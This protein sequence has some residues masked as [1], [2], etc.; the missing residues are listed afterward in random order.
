MKYLNS[1][2]FYNIDTYR[3]DEVNCYERAIGLCLASYKKEYANLFFM[4]S[5]FK[6]CYYPMLKDSELMNEDLYLVR[7]YLNLDCSTVVIKE[8]N[9]FS[10][11]EERLSKNCRVIVLGNLRQ[12]SYSEFYKEANWGHPF[13]IKGFD[14]QKRIFYILDY[15]HLRSNVVRES[16][17]TI[18]YD[19]LKSIFC[20]YFKEIEN[21]TSSFII[22]FSGE[23]TILHQTKQIFIEIMEYVFNQSFITHNEIELLKNFKK[24]NDEDL[25]NYL[26]N[27]PKKK[28][29]F[30]HIMLDYLHANSL[31]DSTEVELLRNQIDDLIKK[32]ELFISVCYKNILKDYNYN[33]VEYS[34][35]TLNFEQ[36]IFTKVKEIFYKNK[37]LL[38]GN[39]KET[40]KESFL[41]ENNDNIIHR[42]NNQFN[43]YF[44]GKEIYNSWFSDD[45]PK[46]VVKK[47]ISSEFHIKVNIVEN[48]DQA[49]FVAGLFLR[50]NGLYFFG[51]D[52]SARIILDKSDFNPNIQSIGGE[53]NEI[54]IKLSFQ[55]EQCVLWY[56]KNNQWKYFYKLTLC[57]GSI[58][59][60]FGCKTYNSPKPLIVSFITDGL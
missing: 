45:S 6:H 54:E 17:F 34:S 37:K 15:L 55:S 32:W 16:D 4:L 38:L 48:R 8:D 42:N 47:N 58:E 60:G 13:I 56:K 35:E 31:V 49:N 1:E 23:D 10:E 20:S 59:Y 53:F 27:L 9:F 28:S 57:K 50:N 5:Q 26:F 44:D 43:F 40:K 22:L 11:L 12:L 52:S 2:V 14:S 29:V 51:I 19:D 24:T 46:V 25:I 30:F 18:T 21:N 36:D 3:L 41:I 33:L 7:K 39:Y